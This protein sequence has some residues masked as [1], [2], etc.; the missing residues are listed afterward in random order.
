[1]SLTSGKGRG[2]LAEAD[3]AEAHFVEHVKLFRD[4]GNIGKELQRL[5]HITPLPSVPEWL[6]GVTNLR[7]EVLSVV[8]LR[9]LLGLAAPESS[10]AQRLIVVRSTLEDIATGWIVDRVIGVRGLAAEDLQPCSTLTS[11]AAMRFLSGIVE[12]EDRLIAV[13]DVNRV[14][15][16]P[17]M[18]QFEPTWQADVA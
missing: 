12:C 3:V 17:E 15:S 4:L 7:G 2:G 1:L 14:L 6:R 10:V 11:G 16:S 5:P 13:L 9:S 18:R 8:D